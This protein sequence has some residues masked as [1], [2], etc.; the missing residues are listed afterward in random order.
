MDRLGGD[1]RPLEPHLVDASGY[2]LHVRPAQVVRDE[3]LEVAPDAG[4]AAD[5]RVASNRDA[6]RRRAASREVCE[7]LDVAVP[8]KEYAVGEDHTVIDDAVVPDVTV[9]HEVVVVPNA[10]HAARL[11]RGAVSRDALA[12]D[13]PVPDLEPRR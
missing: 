4:G 12:E 10:R 9:P 3:G 13:V 11:G 6:M 8:S 5:E 2:R 7:G 1:S